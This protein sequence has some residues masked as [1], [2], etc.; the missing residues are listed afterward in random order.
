MQTRY[1][2]VQLKSK[3]QIKKAF[4]IICCHW[5]V[6]SKRSCCWNAIQK[7]YFF[8]IASFLLVEWHYSLCYI[9]LESVATGYP[10]GK[11]NS[12]SCFIGTL[13]GSECGTT[14]SKLNITQETIPISLCD[15]DVSEHLH[16]TSVTDISTEYDLILT[17]AGVFEYDEEYISRTTVCPK[18]RYQ[19]G[20]GW[21]QKRVCRYPDH[22]GKA[23]PDRSINKL[24]SKIIFHELINLVPVGSGK[25]T[26]FALM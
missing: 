23:K 11:Y 15:K 1:F 20:G 13:I 5:I 25:I 10:H 6:C 18:H 7:F 21:F 17:R 24:Q 9:Q 14:S 3:H 2:C 12:M 26:L 4:F 22:I 19:L 16:T 8:K